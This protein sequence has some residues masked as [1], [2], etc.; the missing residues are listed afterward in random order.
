MVEAIPSSSVIVGFHPKALTRETSRTFLGV[1]L[2][3]E[4]SHSIS[5]AKPAAAATFPAKSLIE[6]SSPDQ[7][8]K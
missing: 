1:P 3:L 6:R 2:G 8:F 4:E 5:P 7:T